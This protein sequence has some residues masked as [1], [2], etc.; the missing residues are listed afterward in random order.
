[1]AGNPLQFPGIPVADAWMSTRKGGETTILSLAC[2][3]VKQTISLALIMEPEQR[4]AL[5]TPAMR[6]AFRAELTAKGVEAI[7]KDAKSKRWL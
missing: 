1:M 2:P 5:K 7:L 6:T 3:K 4:R